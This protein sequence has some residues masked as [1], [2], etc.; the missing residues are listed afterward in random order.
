MSRIPICD[1]E[2]KIL[3]KEC[4]NISG[5]FNARLA[6]HRFDLPRIHTHEMDAEWDGLLDA[7]FVLD[8]LPATLWERVDANGRNIES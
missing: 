1:A 5:L 2:R 6:R 8:G 7:W 4:D 3:C